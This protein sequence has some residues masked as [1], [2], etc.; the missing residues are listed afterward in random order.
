MK[1]AKIS[2]LEQALKGEKKYNDN[3]LHTGK[4][5]KMLD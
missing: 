5:Q 2:E 4:A 3:L 1:N